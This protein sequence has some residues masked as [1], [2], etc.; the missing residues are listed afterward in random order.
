MR[1]SDSALVDAAVLSDR[2]IAD[3]FLPD[4][5]IDLVRRCVSPLEA[6][7]CSVTPSARPHS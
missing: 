7:L 4:K 1:I 3:R 5:A 6:D 2:Y